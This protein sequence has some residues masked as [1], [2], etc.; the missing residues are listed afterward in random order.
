METKLSPKN[1]DEQFLSL[2]FEMFE[3]DTTHIAIVLW[4]RLTL[5]SH[6]QQQPQR[7]KGN[8]NK[9]CKYSVF[10]FD[11]LQVSN[12]VSHILINDASL[13][14]LLFQ[15]SFLL[16]HART[17]TRIPTRARRVQLSN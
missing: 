17:E 10:Y 14:K 2:V 13:K 16:C 8:K 1:E 5:I 3:D 6:T 9:F 7:L 12:I 4:V 11:Y 15:F